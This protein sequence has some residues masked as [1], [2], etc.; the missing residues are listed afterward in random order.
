MVVVSVNDVSKKFRLYASRRDRIKEALSP[1]RW[2]LHEDF[3]ALNRVNI[4]V[5]Q[6]EILGI[7]GKNGS[8]KTTLLKIIAGILTPSSG[9]VE[10]RGRP[11]VLFDVGTGFNPQYTGL[12][13]VYFYGSLLGFRKKEMEALLPE[14][15]EFAE[16][17]DYIGQP[18][19]TY[20]SGMR[21]RL[22]YAVAVHVDPDIL[23]LD[24]VLAVGDEDFRK[25]CANKMAEIFKS[26]KT[27]IY[28]SHSIQSLK[29]LCTRGILLDRGEVLTEGPIAG[30]VA[31]Y[32]RL[33]SAGKSEYESVRARIKK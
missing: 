15:T 8:G 5:R 12:E 26:G 19:R 18:L 6:G 1:F 7:V 9:D 29:Q 30:V 22:G 20:S 13:N 17:G 27:V 21:A 10:V 24:E 33:S 23:I 14:I 32:R 4:E 25:K 28:V 16:I 11:I 2:K 31:R 3:T